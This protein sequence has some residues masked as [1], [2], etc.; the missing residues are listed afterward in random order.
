MLRDQLGAWLNKAGASAVDIAAIESA[1][2]E[3]VTNAVEHAYDESGGR[4]QM[5]GLIDGSG[6]ACMTAIDREPGAR[7]ISSRGTAVG[8]SR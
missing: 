2:L 6:R 1:V 8:G 5:E 7:P 3:A 4:V